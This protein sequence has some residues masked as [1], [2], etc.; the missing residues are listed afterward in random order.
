VRF[1]HI[2]H[3]R[4]GRAGTSSAPA[5]SAGLRTRPHRSG[6]VPSR[7]IFEKPTSIPCSSLIGSMTT[8]AQNTPPSLR[9]RQP[10]ASAAHA[11][12]R[13]DRELSRVLRQ[14]VERVKF[15]M[16]RQSPVGDNVPRVRELLRRMLDFRPRRDAAGLVLTRGLDKVGMAR[17]SAVVAMGDVAGGTTQA[18]GIGCIRRSRRNPEPEVTFNPCQPRR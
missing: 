2:G 9:T 5:S 17:F 14:R 11:F 13:R 18:R 3:P 1:D 15:I 7:V 4:L 16:R 6:T 8:F 10:L 12:P